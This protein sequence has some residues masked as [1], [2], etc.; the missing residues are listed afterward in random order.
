MIIGNSIKREMR[1]SDFFFAAAFFI[2]AAG[3]ISGSIY[4]LKTADVS[5]EGIKSYLE[6]FM[7]SGI[8]KNKL[9][10]CKCAFKENLIIFLIIFISG[11]FRFGI[12]F[13]AAAVIRK[14]FVIGF[15]VSSFIK[16]YGLNG[17]L[18]MS[19][20]MPSLLIIIPA[21][22]IFLAISV[23]FS[24]SKEKN[25]KNFIFSYIFFGIFIFTIF[26]AAAFSEG[27]L[28]TTFMKW[29]FPKYN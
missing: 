13:S 9:D 14:G 28:T 29:S 12:V 27:Y 15:T 19:A 20:T 17:L 26:C 2:L 4:L 7:K 1:N 11:F 18:I 16:F 8:E 22:L 21:L 3:V 5:G 25:Q 23:N 10:V 24:L 6:T